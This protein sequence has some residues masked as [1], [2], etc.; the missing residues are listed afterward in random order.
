M[1]ISAASKITPLHALDRASAVPAAAVGFA[2]YFI[3]RAIRGH[4]GIEL[5]L[6]YQELPPE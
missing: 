6:A 4:Q 3:S 2:I 1:L 5:D